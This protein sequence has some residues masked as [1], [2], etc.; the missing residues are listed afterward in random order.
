MGFEEILQRLM[1]SLDLRLLQVTL[2][3]QALSIEQV[4][5]FRRLLTK[6]A[7]GCR[8]LLRRNLQV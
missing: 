7:C 8:Q 1:L 6:N 3:T 5:A 4:E 2:N